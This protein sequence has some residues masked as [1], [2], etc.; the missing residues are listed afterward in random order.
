ME[1]DVLSLSSIATV[2]AVSVLHAA[3]GPDHYLP[4]ILLGRARGWTLRRTLW[5]TAAC[6]IGHVASSLVLGSVGLLLGAGVEAIAGVEAE[7]GAIAAWGLVAFGLAYGLWGLRQA[8]RS[9]IH[10]HAGH[11]H[12]H[13]GGEH[14]HEH[15]EL[16]GQRGAT[17]WALFLVFVLGPCELLIPCFVMPAS[18]GRWGLAAVL[19]A[20]FAVATLATM[21][22]L[23]ALGARWSH[24]ASLGKLERWS[25]AF[26]G[27]IVAASGAAILMAPI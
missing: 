2:L 11:M 22:G 15:G 21:L 3:I 18:Q 5:V 25:H 9:R 24:K 16:P 20:G 14:A 13:S 6:G 23:V 26:A 17:T 27:G 12:L 8:L 10:S 4:F 19:A 7:R 1:L